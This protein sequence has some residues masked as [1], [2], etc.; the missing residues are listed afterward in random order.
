[1]TSVPLGGTGAERPAQ[2]LH[3]YLLLAQHLPR[4][5]LSLAARFTSALRPQATVTSACH[6]AFSSGHP[7]S[8]RCQSRTSPQAPSTP[9][10]CISADEQ[11]WP[12]L[13][14]IRFIVRH[15][16]GLRTPRD[17]LISFL[18]R[19]LTATFLPLPPVRVPSTISDDL[20]DHGH[21]VPILCDVVLPIDISAHS[22]GLR[23]LEEYEHDSD[24]ARAHVPPR[25]RV[26]RAA[27]SAVSAPRSLC[28]ARMPLLGLSTGVTAV[29]TSFA[30]ISRHLPA[31]HLLLLAFAPIESRRRIS[32][33][34]N[35]RTVPQGSRPY[36]V[37][38]MR[39]THVPNA[40]PSRPPSHPRL[41]EP[42]VLCL[43]LLL[44]A[45]RHGRLAGASETAGDDVSRDT[46]LRDM[47]PP[48][49]NLQVLEPPVQMSSMD[50]RG[51][52]AGGRAGECALRS[53]RPLTWRL[54]GSK[55]L[56]V[57]DCPHPDGGETK[58]IWLG[59][60]GTV[61]SSRSLDLV[62]L[63]SSCRPTP[64]PT[65]ST[66]RL[67]PSPSTA[68]RP[69]P[70]APIDQPPFISPKAIV[71]RVYP[72]TICIFT[73]TSSDQFEALRRSGSQRDGFPG[74]GV[75]VPRPRLDLPHAAHQAGG[76][77]ARASDSRRLR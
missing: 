17:P 73:A 15:A 71:L 46:L 43:V 3:W 1:M 57:E 36:P 19:P 37:I 68:G 65:P 63:H 59:R 72:H 18:S 62:M 28:P 53:H 60:S 14:W 31:H 47:L 55:I 70:L 2:E 52:R 9:K 66:D 27:E 42:R 49:L 69:L 5:R 75:T 34:N 16:L 58:R 21:S 77:D 50:G 10:A 30:S 6:L 11:S 39:T 22:A 67:H 25:K 51:L 35:W 26:P 45:A 76:G 74:D 8:Q 20:D 44:Q 12:T 7:Y 13:R 33:D 4:P 40:P 23:P 24:S 41:R 48:L 61:P 32:M 56:G 29:D 38:L 54:A 64:H